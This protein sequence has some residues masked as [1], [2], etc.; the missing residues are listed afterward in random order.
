MNGMVLHPGFHIPIC[1]EGYIRVLLSLKDSAHLVQSPFR[2]YL[3]YCLPLGVGMITFH[4]PLFS[5]LFNPVTF[6]YLN[7]ICLIFGWWESLDIDFTFRL[8]TMY[9]YNYEGKHV[10]EF[11]Q[12]RPMIYK[13]GQINWNTWFYLLS[14]WWFS[15]ELPENDNLQF[16]SW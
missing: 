12:R 1:N 2:T 16:F 14:L 3:H 4:I 10:T 8:M 5:G 6:E 13:S 15:I 7:L 9:F 11:F